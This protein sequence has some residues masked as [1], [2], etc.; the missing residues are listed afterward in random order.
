MIQNVRQVEVEQTSGEAISYG[1]DMSGWPSSPSALGAVT[2]EDLTEG[3]QVDVSDAVLFGSGGVVGV[4]LQLPR[5][6]GLTA[7]HWYRVRATY[8]T[9]TGDTLEVVIR[10]RCPL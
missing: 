7:G 3:A 6:G 9:S 5:L 1:I 4:V 8:T 10:V 2:V